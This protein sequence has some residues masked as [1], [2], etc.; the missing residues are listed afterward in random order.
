MAGFTGRIPKRL[1]QSF[2]WRSRLGH[3]QRRQ[4]LWSLPRSIDV[5]NTQSIRPSHRFWWAHIGQ[6]RTQIP[7][8]AWNTLIRQ[9]PWVIRLVWSQSRHQTIWTRFGGRGLYGRGCFGAARRCLCRGHI[10]HR[11]IG[12]PHQ[13]IVAPQRQTV[14][15]FWWRFGWPQSRMAGAWKRLALAQRWQTIG[16]F[17]LTRWWR[18]RQLHQN[19]WQRSFWRCIGASQ[20]SLV[21][22]FVCQATA[23]LGLELA[24]TS[25]QIGATSQ[26][27]HRPDWQCAGT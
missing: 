15:L 27:T 7:E 8:F 16:V 25:S 9:R 13:N 3:Q 21:S 24:W 5:S 17:I 10:G 23:R 14:F 26:S 18:P 12:G 1:Q 11:H 4:A 22:L 20:P 19:P 6:R 2:A